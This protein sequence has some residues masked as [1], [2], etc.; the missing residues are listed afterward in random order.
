MTQTPADWYPDPDGGGRLR[1]WDGT[2]W[3]AHVA[4]APVQTMP[5]GP[6][7]PDG[8]PLAGWWWRVLAFVI[9][10][11]ITGFVAGFAS[12]P[13][14]IQ[15]QRDL[16]PVIERFVEEVERNPE[17]QPNL[18]GF[19]AE[20]YGEYLDALQANWFWLVVPTVLITT[21]YWAFFLRWKGATPG[22]L[23]LGLR[24]RLRDE[25]GTLPWW[26]IVTRI[27]IQF[28]VLWAVSAVA[29][30]TGSVALLGFTGVF[31]LIWLIDPL[32]AVWDQNRQTLH[33][34]LARTNV[35]KTR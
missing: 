16:T 12:L 5:T 20:F 6:T 1:Y 26:S 15:I 11:F 30:A 29:L 19:Y 28:G 34:K 32:W 24:V 7:T 21:V 14:Y 10:S 9:D 23:M 17:Q 8:E 3:T 18:T 2:A 25:P 27:G 33:D 35:V 22:K 4:P 13:G 31:F